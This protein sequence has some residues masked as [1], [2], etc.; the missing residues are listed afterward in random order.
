MYM[1]KKNW[2]FTNYIRYTESHGHTNS[3]WAE[4][5]CEVTVKGFVTANLPNIVLSPTVK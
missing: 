5:E 4:L 3:C 2:L 1:K